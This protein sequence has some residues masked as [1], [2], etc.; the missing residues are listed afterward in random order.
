MPR[1]NRNAAGE[2]PQPPP[3]PKRIDLDRV[4]LVAPALRVPPHMNHDERRA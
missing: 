4:P 3:L 2:R 1:R